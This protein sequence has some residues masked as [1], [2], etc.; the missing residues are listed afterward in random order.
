MRSLSFFTLISLA[1]ICGAAPS[2][3]TFVNLGNLNSGQLSQATGV[4]GNGQVVVGWGGSS[5]GTQAWRTATAGLL[6][7][8]DL[9]GGT[10][11]SYA[12][13][14]SNDGTV[15]VGQGQSATGTTAVRW[16]TAGMTSLGDLSGG[17]VFSAASA[18]NSDGTVVVGQS[19]ATNG[20]TA[21]RW[22]TAG[23]LAALGDLP[24]G[25]WN[26]VATAVS[27][28][29]TKVFGYSTSS[30]GVEAFCWTSAT[31]IQAL[32]AL[33]LTL[34]RCYPASVNAAGTVLVGNSLSALGPQA[35]RWENNTFVGLGDLPGGVFQSTASAVSADGNTIV[36]NGRTAAGMEAFVWTA[37]FGMESLRDV[38]TSGGANFTGWTLREATG[39]SAD[40]QTLVGYGVNPQS[41]NE[42]FR[43]N[44]TKRSFIIDPDI[45]GSAP[46]VDRL[47]KIRLLAPGSATQLQ[48]VVKPVGGDGMIRF[49]LQPRATIDVTVESPGFLRRRIANT[50]AA[51]DTL[52]LGSVKLFAGD[53]DGDNEVSILDY[54]AIAAAFEAT[55]GQARFNVNADF[56][57][58]DEITILDFL[59]LSANF[60]M[61]GDL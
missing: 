53:I 60:G 25:V 28:D 19:G 4:S 50:S 46:D 26:S 36:G 31:G 11:A 43:V 12:V 6:A 17:T 61:A 58:D 32:G 49:R 44:L 18:V 9:P 3:S 45:P 56:D 21:F 38:L 7:M 34:M 51:T 15:Q 24:G 2:T 20:V 22:A 33:D 55:V 5:L 10:F 37:E 27:S 14:A 54:L 42:A 1:S 23:G 41:I 8:G 35:F 52:N 30:R 16:T 47:W 39:I 13:A 59:Q 29:G 57:S 48:E 40:G